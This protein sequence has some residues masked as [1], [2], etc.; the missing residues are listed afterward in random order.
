MEAGN[1]T[2][3]FIILGLTDRRELQTV[4]FFVFL[5][6]YTITVM[7]NLGIIVLIVVNSSLH[8][9]MYF[10]L[11]NLS[12]VDLGYS[13]CVVPK[14]LMSL[15]TET[16]SIFFISCALQF[17]FFASFVISEFYILVI[18]AFDR[19][20]AICYPLHYTIK[21]SPRFCV[22]LVVLSHTYGFTDAMTQTILTFRLSYCGSRKI[23]GFFC[24][25]PSL[26]KISCSDLR[27]KQTVLLM[28]SGF[29]MSITSICILVSYIFIISAILRMS[30]AEAR[31][32]TFSTCSSHLMS[33]LLFYG[34]LCFMYL[35]PN[36]EHSMNQD[37]VVTIFY[38]AIIPMLNPMIYSLRNQEVKEALKKAFRRK[39]H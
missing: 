1:R 25:D 16:K 13:T 7:G 31:Y 27:I 36:S 22:L 21:M 4:I 15:A 10:F 17:Y 2:T 14:L 19:Y 29:N 28:S 26:L 9:P 18:M 30:S 11:A 23:E 39:N 38:S 34:T 37:K 8:K 6:I 3:D 12:F 32:K 20:M 33:V 5:L 24:S 35:R